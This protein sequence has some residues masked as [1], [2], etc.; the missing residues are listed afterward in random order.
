MRLVGEN[1]SL[2]LARIEVGAK[3]TPAGGDVLLGVSVRAYGYSASDQVW[4]AAAA[5]KG[6]LR[7]M[8]AL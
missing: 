5:W 4:I 1:A 3:G 7:E 8:H 2:E 6:F